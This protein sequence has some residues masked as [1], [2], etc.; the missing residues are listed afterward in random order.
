MTSP[1]QLSG[2]M[3]AGV[4]CDRDLIKLGETRLMIVKQATLHCVR[5]RGNETLQ[6][7]HQIL[8]SVGC[9]AIPT[10]DNLCL[11]QKI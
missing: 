6:K 4:A 9:A 11:N 2:I 3:K 5:R 7:R 1:R 10:C 8:Q